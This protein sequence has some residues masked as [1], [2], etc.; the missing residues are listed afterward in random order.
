MDEI[1][2]G[3]PVQFGF[4]PIIE[5]EARL[6]SADSLVLCG[7]GG[8]HLS[9]GLMKIYNPAFDIYVHRDYG[10]PL[11]SEKRFKNSLY[12]A[13]SYSGN[14]EEVLDF[15][16]QAVAAKRDVAIIATGGKLIEFAEDN[17]LAYIQIPDIGAQPRNAIWLSIIALA[18]LLGDDDA[19][20]EIKQLGGKLNPRRF[21][22]QGKSLAAALKN[23]IPVVYSS[24]T[25]LSISYIWK[26]KFNE[27][28]K[29]P[30]FYNVFPE[31]NHNEMNG[32]DV[33]DE[34][35]ELSSK[36]HFILLEDSDD[37]PRIMRRM[38]VLRKLYEDRGLPVSVV[39]LSG[40]TVFEKI[41]N[42]L[43]LADWVAYGLSETYRIEPNKVAMI[44]EF[45]KLIS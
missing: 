31:L 27:T 42:S 17:H 16:E 26:I 14:T 35:R 12:V 45:K 37:Q 32:F 28:A 11:L 5:N 19:V 30:A 33:T 13:S 21:E 38:L 15:A 29:I 2:K 41:F 39:Q 23:K 25:N 40:R 3:I 44:E 10:L 18:K 6:K 24:R 1:I 34:T 7:M 36:F 9:A 8:S 4:N 22:E 43:L 20:A